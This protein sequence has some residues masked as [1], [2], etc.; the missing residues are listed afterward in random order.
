MPFAITGIPVMQVDVVEVLT[1]TDSCP[2]GACEITVSPRVE[3]PAE[4]KT[5]I[6]LPHQEKQVV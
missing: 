6:V 1:T 2:E 3:I 4:N 5:G